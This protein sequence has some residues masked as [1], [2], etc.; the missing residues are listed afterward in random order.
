M[1]TGKALGIVLALGCGF[2]A[3][4]R[5]G[6]TSR[7][8][9]RPAAD[10]AQQAKRLA[11][12]AEAMELGTVHQFR[13][14]LDVPRVYVREGFYE[15]PIET[16]Q[17]TVGILFEYCQDATGATLMTVHDYKSGKEIGN[18]ADWHAFRMK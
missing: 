2:W 13:P 14:D 18:V 16:K 1:S 12:L 6:C 17:Q 5:I 9:A 3:L 7:P 10:P 15:L 11:F 4:E 8:A